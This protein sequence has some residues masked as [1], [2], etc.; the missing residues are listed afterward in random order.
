MALVQPGARKSV[1]G[2][3]RNVAGKKKPAVVTPSGNTVELSDYAMQRKEP[4]LTGQ[5][6]LD[7]VNTTNHKKFQTL[8]SLRDSHP[9][10]LDSS[11]NHIE[12]QMQKALDGSEEQ[13]ATQWRQK[14]SN[15]QKIQLQKE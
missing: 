1:S 12:A 4:V 3:T 5:T 11:L 10:H 13:R 9:E 8:V 6:D 2:T 15:V 7:F 14:Y